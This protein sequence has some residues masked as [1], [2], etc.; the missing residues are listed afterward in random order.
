[1]TFLLD[2]NMNLVMKILAHVLLDTS[3]MVAARVI[4][5]LQVQLKRNHVLLVNSLRILIIMK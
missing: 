4:T 1:V 5:A 2:I 3:T